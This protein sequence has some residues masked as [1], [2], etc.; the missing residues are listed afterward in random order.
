MSSVDIPMVCRPFESFWP[1]V[2][3][4]SERQEVSWWKSCYDEVDGGAA[5]LATREKCFSNWEGVVPLIV[6]G[7]IALWF[8]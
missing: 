4:M 3:V 6:I 1:L 8:M 5:G 7:G 2:G